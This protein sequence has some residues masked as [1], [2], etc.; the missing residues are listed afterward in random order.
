VGMPV[1]TFGKPVADQLGL[2]ARRVVHDDVDVEI[3][4][5][6]SLD[7]IEK[8]TEL[9]GTMARHAPTDDRAGLNVQR[10]E[11]RG[12]AVSFV[13]VRTPF[14]LSWEGP[15]WVQPVWKWPDFGKQN[16]VCAWTR[17]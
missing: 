3:A 5:Q 12:R 9:G 14:G 11:Q 17:R 16:T 15:Q 6:V 4:G 7:G 10:G 2:V 8:A 13:V 1:R